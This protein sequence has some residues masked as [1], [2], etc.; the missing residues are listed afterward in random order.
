MKRILVFVGAMALAVGLTGCGET[1]EQLAENKKR[2]EDLGGVY[3]QW[4]DGLVGGQHS[5]CYFD[6]EKT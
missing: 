4:R 2:C 5:T 1:F 3:E 6:E